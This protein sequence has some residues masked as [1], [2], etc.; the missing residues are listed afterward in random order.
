MSPR[1]F[2]KNKDS[3]PFWIGNLNLLDPSLGILIVNKPPAG[4]SK[5]RGFSNAFHLGKY[6]MRSFSML[7]RNS[8]INFFG[9]QTPN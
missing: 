7:T 9:F 4:S 3:D 8:R 6:F 1:E 5:Q 2:I